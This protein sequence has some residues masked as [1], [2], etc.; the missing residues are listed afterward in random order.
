MGS[1]LLPKFMISLF[2]TNEHY[3]IV[4]MYHMFIIHSLLVGHL[5]SFH[6]LLFV[7]KASMKVPEQ[8]SLEYDTEFF[9]HMP[10]S[11]IN[12]SCSRVIFISLRILYAGFHSVVI[13]SVCNFTNSEF[14]FLFPTSTPAF[15]VGYCI[16]LC[17]FYCNKRKSQ[18]F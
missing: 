14:G 3:S 2:F 18:L 11:G 17:H 4:N 6:L 5:G 10:R 16:D 7:N 8:V 13:A 9:G 1:L 15:L 12:E